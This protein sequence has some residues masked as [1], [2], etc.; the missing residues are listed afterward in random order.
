[1]SGTAISVGAFALPWELRQED[2]AGLRRW[3]RICSAVLVLAGIVIPWLPLPELERAQ[4]E[5]VAIEP[6]R[7]L[8]EAPRRVVPPPPPPAPATRAPQAEPPR[9]APVPAREIASEI[10]PAAAPVQAAEPEPTPDAREVAASAGLLALKDTLAGLRGAVNT[11]KLANAGT[12]SQGGGAA[13]TVDQN[14][15]AARQGARS[16][17][18]N[19]ST[20]SRATGGV[21]LAGRDTTRVDAPAA[22]SSSGATA[23][24]QTADPRQRSIEDIRRVFDANKGAIFA[25]YQR[26]LRADPSLR[27]EVVLE[28]LIEPG[29]TVAEIRV[30][31]SELPDDELM[32]RL[33]SRIRMFD[34]GA[35]DVGATRISYPV[36]F[37][38][39]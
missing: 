36:H 5:V 4:P 30:V 1:V 18:V 28:L 6:T 27:G 8:L 25:I 32:S 11:G 26:A 19:D 13:A 23:A 14:R 33:V 37:L 29:G 17:G 22:S 21:A 2:T 15:L 7:I 31:A 34:F 16:A 12:S 39:S 35:K 38:P 10:A 3:L 9:P 24:G 20:L